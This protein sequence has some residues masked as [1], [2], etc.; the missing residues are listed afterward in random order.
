MCQSLARSICACVYVRAC[1][2]SFAGNCY[3]ERLPMFLITS[4][5]LA[6]NVT[7]FN[8]FQSRSVT[9]NSSCHVDCVG[10]CLQVSHCV[11]HNEMWA[12]SHTARYS[13]SNVVRTAGTLVKGN[14]PKRTTPPP[15]V[16]NP[17][18]N[19]NQTQYN[20]L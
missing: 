8:L 18:T 2:R 20:S 5:A 3:Q 19:E 6:I 14:G 1:C 9:V 13:A 15:Q 17:V 12:E 4:C 16:R 11:D 7:S 10:I